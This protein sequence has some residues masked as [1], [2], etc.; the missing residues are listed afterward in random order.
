MTELILMMCYVALVGIRMWFVSCPW[1]PVHNFVLDCQLHLAG[2]DP[3][4]PTRK[5]ARYESQVSVIP[6]IVKFR[7]KA[8]HDRG[9]TFFDSDKCII[10][11]VNDASLGKVGGCR[12]IDGHTVNPCNASQF[13]IVAPS[14]V[15]LPRQSIWHG[16][17]TF[18]DCEG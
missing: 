11:S 7:G 9:F 12:F 15:G 1:N 13:K 18:C 4:P 10:Q 17:A 16:K 8:L 3:T 14:M 5:R 6:P 2:T